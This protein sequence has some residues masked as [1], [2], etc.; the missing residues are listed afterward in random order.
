M[1]R[2]DPELVAD[3]LEHIRILHQHLDRSDLADATVADAVSLR[4][5]AAIECLSIASQGLRD[6]VFGGEWPVAWSTRNR[7]AH[8]YAH[9]DSAIIRATVEKDLPQVEAALRAELTDGAEA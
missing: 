3:A 7:I 6:R 2:S 4:L 8:G 1:S 5:A 9:I